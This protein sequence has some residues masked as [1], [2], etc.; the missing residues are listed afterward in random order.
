M[1]AP[2]SSDNA[3]LLRE[4][5]EAA[6]YTDTNLAEKLGT[7]I[8]PPHHHDQVELFQQ[9]SSDPTPFG[10]LV[11]LF[12]LGTAIAYDEATAVL[13]SSFLNVCLDCGL[14]TR[15]EALLE[16]NALLVPCDNWLLAADL[17]PANLSS[18]TEYVSHISQPALHLLLVAVRRSVGCTLDLCGGLGLHGIAASQ[19]SEQVVCSDVNPRAKAYVE[20]NAALN[21]CPQIKAV[22]SDVFSEIDGKFGLILC[23]PPFVI[24]PL[25]ETTFRS[26][27]LELDQFVENLLRDG[28]EYLEEGGYFQMICEWAEIRDQDWQERLAGMLKDNG[29]DAWILHANRQLPETYARSRL[30]ELTSDP[31]EL[32]SQLLTWQQYFEHHNVEAIHGGLIFLRRRLGS[33]WSDITEVT[34]PVRQPIGEFIETSFANRDRLLGHYSDE[35]FLASRLAIATG[36]RMEERSCWNATNW[37]SEGIKLELE[38]GVPCSL[39]VDMQVRDLLMRF[40]GMRTVDAVLGEFASQLQIPYE[41]AKPQCLEILR[42]MIKV[43]CLVFA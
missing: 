35:E 43:G 8:P 14:L 21:D 31:D 13:P 37:Q 38:S 11:R 10:A 27:S 42:E 5:C 15:K 9:L 23:N 19:F 41:N 20:F 33:N 39:G 32:A 7:R 17:H 29:C 3:E 4:V 36:L 16:P 12:F 40:D 25:A 6:L 22:T 2:V 28:P 34:K 18:A 26:N 30:R 24:T 1:L